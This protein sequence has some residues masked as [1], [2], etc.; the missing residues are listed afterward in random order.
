MLEPTLELPPSVVELTNSVENKV[1]IY[2]QQAISNTRRL[3]E[4]ASNGTDGMTM[5]QAIAIIAEY[6]VTSQIMHDLATI[7]T[8][9]DKLCKDIYGGKEALQRYSELAVAFAR[10][11]GSPATCVRIDVNRFKETND[12]YGHDQADRVLQALAKAMAGRPYDLVIREG[13]DEFTAILINTD[14]AGGVRYAQSVQQRFAD[15][16]SGKI[17]TPEGEFPPM[18]SQ[19]VTVGVAQLGP[20]DTAVDFLVNADDALYV[21]KHEERGVITVY[22]P[23]DEKIIERQKRRPNTS[24]GQQIPPTADLMPTALPVTVP[25]GK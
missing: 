13:G 24:T 2:R 19:S 4:K 9:T 11:N 10:R 6:Q 25:T 21:G 18:E 7:K 20:D 23:K 8:Q 16:Q 1:E 5:D 3:V 17:K 12:K 14:S 15:I 22:N